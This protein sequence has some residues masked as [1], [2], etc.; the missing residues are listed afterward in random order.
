[1]KQNTKQ[2]SLDQVIHL[3]QLYERIKTYEIINTSLFLVL[4]KNFNCQEFNSTDIDKAIYIDKIIK[5][6]NINTD[7]DN[8]KIFLNK[9]N[10]FYCMKINIQNSK[11]DFIK[12]N[13]IQSK[14][15]CD[16]KFPIINLDSYLS[17]YLKTLEEELA[18]KINILNKFFNM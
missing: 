15:I 6:F 10:V 13:N 9:N 18:F 8:P 4:F 12:L 2:L 17:D 16:E 11:I 3:T 14:T 5:I 1:M 7:N